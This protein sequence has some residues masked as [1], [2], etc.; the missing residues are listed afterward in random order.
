MNAINAGL[1]CTPLFVFLPLFFIRLRRA[2]SPWLF[3]PGI[4]LFATCGVGLWVAP[5]LALLLSVRGELQQSNIVLLCGAL[6]LTDTHFGITFISGGLGKTWPLRLLF[7]CALVGLMTVVLGHS[8]S[9]TAAACKI[10]LIVIGF[11]FIEQVRQTIALYSRKTDYL[12]MRSEQTALAVFL[13]AMAARAIVATFVSPELSIK[14]FL[15]LHMPQFP[16]FPTWAIYLPEATMFVAFAYLLADLLTQLFVRKRTCPF[17]MLVLLLNTWML[18]TITGD[19]SASIWIF[20]PAF[21]HA[22]QEIA[23]AVLKRTESS[24]FLNTV[25]M[26][27]FSFCIGVAIM[28]IG[29]S[30][31][32][33]FMPAELSYPAIV[34]A[35]SI[36]HFAC[37]FVQELRYQKQSLPSA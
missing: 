11:H 29:S 18:F 37:G 26:L 17:P 16:A 14:T 5:I 32:S 9:W 3:N 19:I 33:R 6:F 30:F 1:L 22:P 35:A 24:Q 7:S 21:F 4:D 20:V 34:V 10:Y 8:E 31:M 2:D 27:V 12:N 23:I 28:F 36:W 25:W 13:Y 15:G